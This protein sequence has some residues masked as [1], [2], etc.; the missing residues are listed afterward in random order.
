MSSQNDIA[1]R[2]SNLSKMFKVYKKPSDLLWD[3]LG[4]PRHADFWALKDISFSVKR[5]EVVGI[6]GRNGAGK[7]T[8]LRILAG[9][10]NKT[11]GEVQINGKVSAILELGTGFHPEHTGRENIYMGGMCLG[12]SRE[13]IDRKIDSII[14]FSEL[15]D[16]IDQPFRTY[17]SGMQARLTF[18]TAISVEPDIFIVDEALAA[19]DAFF[20]PKCLKRIKEI[21]LSGA[22]VLFVSHS[23]DLVKRFCHKCIYIDKGHLLQQGNA[24]DICSIYES[25]LLEISSD[26]NEVKSS[27]Q[28]IKI[29]SDNIK[30]NDVKLLADS[31]PSY[32]FFQHSRVTILI[33]VICNKVINNP[34]VWIRFTRS[35][36]IVATSWLSH[37]PDF[38]DLGQLQKGNNTIDVT[39]DDI[40]LG[41]GFYFLTIAFFP[42][43]KGSE[44]AFYN[45]PLCMWDRV[46]Q[47]EVKRRTRPL[48]TIFDQPMRITMR[49]Y[50]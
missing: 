6:I 43:K 36:G 45:D 10:L 16:V 33:N 50:S 9:T 34:A 47:I 3:I 39:I 4:K 42:E 30:I 13:E 32:A 38:I 23:T 31:G 20:I 41:D 27:G 14:D 15:R 17:S 48:S 2:V 25:L 44:S 49:N 24:L 7:S 37:E 12:M 28:G 21:C 5:G 11:S 19:G 35:D 26:I 18:S 1:I 46:V 29:H 40:M 8:L 22:T